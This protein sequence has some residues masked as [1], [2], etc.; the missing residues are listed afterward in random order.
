MR[1]PLAFVLFSAL[2]HAMSTSASGDCGPAV[3]LHCTGSSFGPC[4]SQHGYWSL[5]PRCPHHKNATNHR[6]AALRVCTAASAVNPT[7][8][9]VAPLRSSN[10]KSAPMAP[11]AAP[12]T[13]RAWGP[14]SG[15]AA[16]STGIVAPRLNTART[17]VRGTGVISVRRWAT[18][19]RSTTRRSAARSAAIFRREMCKTGSVAIC[20]TRFENWDE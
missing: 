5:L 1:L 14:S 20:R 18:R 8:A 2:S 16:H 19:A 7:S 13:T 6:T 11:A 12:T 10:K 4:C 9:P 15:S 3:G 17:S